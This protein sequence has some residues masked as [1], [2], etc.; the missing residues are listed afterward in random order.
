MVGCY[1]EIVIQMLGVLIAVYYKFAMQM[2]RKSTTSPCG[3]NAQG[4]ITA[5]ISPHEQYCFVAPGISI[6]NL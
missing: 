6:E 3:L 5:L 1:I 4:R 2:N